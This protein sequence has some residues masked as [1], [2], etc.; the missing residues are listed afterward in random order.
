[1][2]GRKTQSSL[3]VEMNLGIKVEEDTLQSYVMWRGLESE[4]I[5][6]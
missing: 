6:K 1:M 2:S 5:T 4:Y 3:P